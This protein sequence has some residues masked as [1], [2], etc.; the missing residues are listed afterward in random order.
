MDDWGGNPLFLETPKSTVV[1]FCLWSHEFLPPSIN[2]QGWSSRCGWCCLTCGFRT[3][4]GTQSLTSNDGSGK[5]R[6]VWNKHTSLWTPRIWVKPSQSLTWNLKHCGWNQDDFETFGKTD[7]FY[8]G[9]TGSFQ[10]GHGFRDTNEGV[11]FDIQ[12]WFSWSKKGVA[13]PILLEEELLVSTY[14]VLFFEWGVCMVGTGN[15]QLH[16]DMPCNFPR[17][18]G[19]LVCMD[20]SDSCLCLAFE[21][22]E[23]KWTSRWDNYWKTIWGYTGKCKEKDGRWCISEKGQWFLYFWW[24]KKTLLWRNYWQIHFKSLQ[25]RLLVFKAVAGGGG[26]GGGGGG[27]FIRLCMF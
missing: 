27:V 9:R 4:Y 11:L 17:K 25:A 22:G 26:G 5:M 14:V 16:H 23:T 15:H 1:W 6:D 24:S 8:Q 19:F 20:G 7:L 13:Y 3:S 21:D 18:V 2:P 12:K 10:G